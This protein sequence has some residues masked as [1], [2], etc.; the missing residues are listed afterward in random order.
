M[1]ASLVAQTVKNPPAM[2]RTRV[3]SL[4]GEDPLQK[5]MATHSSI[6]AW[7]ILWTEDSGGVQNQKQAQEHLTAL[8]NVGW[9]HASYIW[10]GPQGAILC[11][12]GCWV[13]SLASTRCR[14][15]APFLHPLGTI[16]ND[17]RHCQMSPGW[18]GREVAKD[19]LV[20]DHWYCP[21]KWI[22]LPASFLELICFVSLTSLTFRAEKV[23]GLSLLY[24]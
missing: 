13:L 10:A 7:K 1:Q 19:P 11:V 3:Q 23:L 17:P 9:F 6:L 14:T 4:G 8:K 21:Q 15:V 22:D 24:R 12:A 5:R 20:G 18:V 2:Q 16:K